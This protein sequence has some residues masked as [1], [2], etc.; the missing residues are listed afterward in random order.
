MKQFLF[1][2]TAAVF[3]TAPAM[4][5]DMPV[6]APPVVVASVF[7]WSGFY[8]GG[9]IG[10]GWGKSDFTNVT[11]ADIS[12]FPTGGGLSVN[13][14]G[15]IGGGQ[16]GYNWQSGQWVIGVEGAYSASGMK[17]DVVTTSWLTPTATVTT[18]SKFRN[19]V[20][21]TAKIGIAQDRLLAYVVGGYAGAN[22]GLDLVRSPGG[23]LAFPNSAF[24]SER[25]H[26]WTIGAGLD[27]AVTRNVTLGVAYNHH[28]F[29][30]K[31]HNTPRIDG[32]ASPP[33]VSN[34]LSATANVAVVRLNYLFGPR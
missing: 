14:R 26:G 31:I 3:L 24:S 30:T 21:G 22:V 8:I 33:T 18:T 10:Y 11:T 6:K 32:S 4:A 15:V 12:F 16:V 20:S 28:N 2:T 19:I 25:H 13:P 7:S 1:G 17:E 23:L 9:N 34:R 27:Y 29:G 5:A